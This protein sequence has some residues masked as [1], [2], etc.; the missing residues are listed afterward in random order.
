MEIFLDIYENLRGTT[1]KEK[2]KGKRKYDFKE[3][4]S[5]SRRE[6]QKKLKPK[7]ISNGKEHIIRDD[8][9]R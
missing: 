6:D 2:G 8:E 4:F 5:G 3:D 7:H 9:A 1:S